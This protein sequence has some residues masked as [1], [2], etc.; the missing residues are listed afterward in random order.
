MS[1]DKDGFVCRDAPRFAAAASAGI[2]SSAAAHA[3]ATAAT[4]VRLGFV[5]IGGRGS[6]HLDAAL[7]I[8]GVEVPAL[9]EIRA[10]RL[11]RAA[12]WVE[13][14]GRPAPRLYGR[15]ER[16]FER[17]CAEEDLDC[18]IC[19]TSWRWHAQVCLAANRHG[20]HAVSEVPI[21]LTVDEAWSL[22]EAFEQTGKWS[23]LALEQVLLEVSDGMYLTLLNM[24]RQGVLGDILHAESGY[25]HDLRRVKFPGGSEPWRLQHA[26]DRNGNLYPDHPMNRIMPAMD[27]NRGD[28]FAQLVSV[29]SR[30]VTLNEYAASRYG[31][32]HPLAARQ[33]AQ[34]DY[35]A[36][37]IRTVDGKL[38]T[39]NFDTNT[40]H[41][42]EFTRIQG[43]DGVFFDGRGMGGPRIYLD[44]ISPES[45][46][47]ED[48]APKMAE[49]RHPLLDSYDPPERPALRG[50][51]GQ[52][53]KTP[54]TWHLLIQALQSGTAPYFDVYD[55]VTSSVISPLSEQSVASGSRPVE[56]PDFTRGQWKTRPP[57]QFPRPTAVAVG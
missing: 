21:V 36:T 3:Q 18:V 30:A 46:Q 16:D 54:L 49:Y 29:S 10:D 15:G 31:S 5:G 9:C 33:M 7:G 47:W 14:S 6:Y 20:K 48:A 4:P 22:V 28:R 17:L 8:E 39:L 23:T 25:V 56:F 40:P 43:T 1:L 19:S 35:N 41:P 38:V 12:A 55:S 2:A 34:G 51:G 42:R 24:I 26:I 11:E 57:I 45:H 37:L 52:S 53:M 27:I 13:H 50:H 44:G 32:E